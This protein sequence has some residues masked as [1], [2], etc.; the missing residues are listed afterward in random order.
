MP[1]PTKGHNPEPNAKSKQW[2]QN[3]WEVQKE[4]QEGTQL[5]TNS[6]DT[7]RSNIC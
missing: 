7:L 3:P 4:K 5:E 2:T 1:K 6:F